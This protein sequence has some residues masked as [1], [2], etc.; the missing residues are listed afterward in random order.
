MTT[1]EAWKREGKCLGGRTVKY[2]SWLLPT[3]EF[4]NAHLFLFCFTGCLPS[5]CGTLLLPSHW[6][7]DESNNVWNCSQLVWGMWI[8]I[9]GYDT[10][11]V[12]WILDT[13]FLRSNPHNFTL[14]PFSW[15]PVKFIKA[16]V[17]NVMLA[18][19]NQ[20]FAN[21]LRVMLADSRHNLSGTKY[22]SYT[23]HLY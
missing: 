17:S 13:L 20:S 18:F 8:L 7:A 16:V 14:R 2:P 15:C 10:P 19:C 11:E 22:V 5:I 4:M 3:T 9:E 12:S 23:C 1:L 21:G 6:T